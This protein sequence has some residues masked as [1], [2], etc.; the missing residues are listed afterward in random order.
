M[1]RT[2][3]IASRFAG[4]ARTANGGVGAGLIAG[5]IGADVTVRLVRPLP[6]ETELVVALG[7]PGRWEVRASGELVATATSAAAPLDI[8][9]PPAP[10]PTIDEARVIATRYAGLASPRSINCF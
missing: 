1:P 8:G 6:L 7:G 5:A 2:F 3:A 9:A 4:P 10:P